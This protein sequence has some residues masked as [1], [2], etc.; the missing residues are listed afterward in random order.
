MGE[1]PS[2]RAWA[3]EVGRPDAEIDL[4]RAALALA[5]LEYRDL[6]IGAYLRQLDELARG[7]ERGQ[8]RG[9]DLGRLHRLREYLF[10]ELGF[11]GNREAYFDP[12]NSFLNEVLDRRLGIPITLCLVLIETGRRLGLPMEG[13]GLPGH[14]IA[15]MRVGQSRILLDPFNGGTILTPEACAEL[16]TCAAGQ[17]VELTEAEL[18]PV[19]QR[20]FLAR[21]LNNL[22]GVY[23]RQAN[24]DRVVAVIDRLL[25]LDPAA[26]AELRDRGLA[27]MNQGDLRRGLA[28]WERY[29]EEFPN[30]P[31]SERVK[32]HLRRLRQKLAV[33]N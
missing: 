1:D 20:R 4:G 6:D 21:V 3:R 10:A 5:R 11:A 33:L 15:G 22:K 13:I 32:G 2:L 8:R 29:L 9:D 24:W 28:D 27:R 18:A 14:F 31:D 26:R 25:V 12:R 16:A 7:A 23:W 19:G 30:A 17:R